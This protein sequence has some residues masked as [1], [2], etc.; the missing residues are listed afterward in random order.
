MTLTPSLR[1]GGRAPCRTRRRCAS[2]QSGGGRRRMDALSTS[3]SRMER[4][5]RSKGEAKTR[6]G[7]GSPAFEGQ[8]LERLQKGVDA[9]AVR[10]RAAALEGT[11]PQLCHRDDRNGEVVGRVFPHAV[12]DTAAAF[13]RIDAGV[14]V[15]QVLHFSSTSIGLPP[16]GRG[17]G[18]SKSA[19]ALR[20]LSQWP[21]G[22]LRRFRGSSSPQ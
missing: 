11:E 9:P 2:P 18:A 1:P 22:Q 6:V 19:D 3:R 17:F 4:P 8:D 7:F 10:L 5:A 14:R 13:Q 15:E 12:D 21:L 16:A 20:Q